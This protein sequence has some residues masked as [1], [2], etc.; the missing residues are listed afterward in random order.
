VGF[1]FNASFKTLLSFAERGFLSK[2]KWKSVMAASLSLI[3][4]L[5][6]LADYAFRQMRLPG[7]VG[8][9]IAGILCGPYVLKLMAPEMMSV[10]ADFRKIA[11][12]V[13]LLRAG[14]ELHRDTLHRVGLAVLIMSCLPA[15]FEIA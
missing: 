2:K 12:I 14:F 11:L 6:L 8:M 3:I 7:L 10:S 5:G 1:Y 15:V 13:I 9:L 4:V